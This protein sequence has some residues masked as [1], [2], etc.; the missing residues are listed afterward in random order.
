MLLLPV[1]FYSE[2][3]CEAEVVARTTVQVT[4]GKSFLHEWKD[5]GLRLLIPADVLERNALPITISIR[6]SVNGYYQ[7][8]K[9]TELMSAVYWVDFGGRLCQPITLELQHSASLEPSKVSSLKFVTAE[10]N[11]EVLPYN[12]EL[13]RGKRFSPNCS[14]GS[15]EMSASAGFAIVK[16]YDERKRY[17]L[18][19]YYICHNPITWKLNIIVICDLQLYQQVYIYIC[20][21]ILCIK[22]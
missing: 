10:Y 13:V 22:Q 21:I 7:L 20:I 17:N 14:Y 4:P 12:F 15:V 11:Q 6:A 9:D 19:T 8:P 18:L 3:T 16:K 2:D 1:F 5:H